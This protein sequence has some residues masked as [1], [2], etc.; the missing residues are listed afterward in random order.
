VFGLLEDRSKLVR[1]SRAGGA[2]VAV[3]T[4]ATCANRNCYHRD[5]GNTSDHS[6]GKATFGRTSSYRRRND[7]SGRRNDDPILHA[8]AGTV[9]HS[10]NF[11]AIVLRINV[12]GKALT[13]QGQREHGRYRYEIFHFLL[14]PCRFFKMHATGL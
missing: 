1:G 9:D 4:T 7:A 6:T 12:F 8:L 10:A 5:S 13:R 2:V 14:L 11:F 3:A